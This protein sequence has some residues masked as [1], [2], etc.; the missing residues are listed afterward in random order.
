M[1]KWNK[2]IVSGSNAHLSSVTSSLGAQ[3]TGSVLVSSSFTLNSTVVGS[4]LTGSFS[5]SFS[6]SFEGTASHA[7]DLQR[8]NNV[9]DNNVN[10]YVVTATGGEHIQGEQY[11]QFDSGFTRNKLTIIGGYIDITDEEQSNLAIGKDTLMSNTSGMWN[12]AIG[13]AS[14]NDNQDGNRNISIGHDSLNA[15]LTG[16]DNIAIGKSSL[17]L[18]EGSSNLA[19]GTD[20]L[21]SNTSGQ[22]NIGI[23]KSSLQANTSGTDNIG[24][25]VGTL[26]SN[27]S[28]FSNISIGTN[29][30]AGNISGQYNIGIGEL[31]LNTNASG[32]N[33]ISLGY[34]SGMRITGNNNISVGSASLYHTSN[35]DSNIGIGIQSLYFNSASSNLAIG[36]NSSYLNRTGSRN[37]SIGNFSLYRNE[38][39]DN[40]SIGVSSSF[41]NFTGSRNLSIGNY[42]LRDLLNGI[43]NIS[44][45]FSSSLNLV[46]ASFNTSVGVGVFGSKRTGSF[47]T[48]I[49]YNAMS[50]IDGGSLDS[51]YNIAIGVESLHSSLPGGHNIGIG[52]HT[53]RNLYVGDLRNAGFN[54]IA[55]GNSAGWAV[56]TGGHVFIGA[57]A[58]SGS[59]VSSVRN[60][61][62]TAGSIIAIGSGSLKE[63]YG[64]LSGTITI[65]FDSGKNLKDS[66]NNIVIGHESLSLTSTTNVDH[67]I[68]IGNS[69][70]QYNS[71]NENVIIGNLSAIASGFAGASNVII[72]NKSG[73]SMTNSDYNVLIGY[74]VASRL[75]TGDFNVVMGGGSAGVSLTTGNYNLILGYQAA[76]LTVNLTGESNIVLGYAAG[77]DLTS[78][79]DNILIGKTAGGNLSTATGSIMIGRE[80]GG[81]T[82]GSA[83]TG[84][85]NI[86]LGEQS[87]FSLTSGI[88]NILIGHESGRSMTT[89]TGSV[90]L[91]DRAGKN[92]TGG[93]NV[94]IGEL[95]GDAASSTSGSILIGSDA[96]GGNLTGNGNVF[97]GLQSGLVASSATKNVFIGNK[98]GDAADTTTGSVVI[99]DNAGDALTSGNGNVFIG[100][101]AGGTITTGRNNIHIGSRAGNRTN[102]PG[103]NVPAGTINSIIIG[104]NVG[105]GA[106]ADNSVVLGGQGTATYYSTIATPQWTATSDENDKTDIANIGLGLDLIRQVQPKKYRW[107]NRGRYDNPGSRD[108][109]L[110]NPYDSWGIIAQDL[111][112]LTSSFAS[113][114]Y[115]IEEISGSYLD[116]TGFI[117]YG[118]KEGSLMWTTLQAV[119]DLDSIVATTGSNSFTGSQFITG[120]LVLTRTSTPTGV[121][122]DLYGSRTKGGNQYFDF[123]RITNTT[124]SAKTP[125]KT[126]RLDISGSIEIINDA[127]TSTIFSLNDSGS[128]A[129][130]A[131]NAVSLDGLKN[132]GGGVSINNGNTVIFDDGNTHIHSAGANQNIWINASGSGNLVVNGQTGASGGLLVGTSTA[133]GLVTISGSRN[134]NLGVTYGYLNSSGAT[135]T[136]SG[137]SRYSIV[138]TDRI[139]G[140]EFNAYSDIRIK[141]ITGKIS[142]D[143]AKKFI[144]NTNPIKFTWK[145]SVD[146]GIKNGYSAQEVL[147]AGFDNLVGAIPNESIEELIDADGFVS[148][149]GSQLTV[150][151]EQI[152]P[153]HSV[154]IKHLLDK[155]EDLEKQ[156]QELRGK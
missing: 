117:G 30:I 102:G 108:G 72:G 35:Y 21:K 148:P 7:K 61:S 110:K 11:L 42:S 65:G 68:V 26:F 144:I 3:F 135:G 111:V 71:G 154:V 143:E 69:T 17:K 124:G 1:A 53:L 79:R 29:A 85:G 83:I 81:D 40:L 36:E 12:I 116:G 13:S 64:T 19:I 128:L 18:N 34:M 131:T 136:F 96:G 107:D 31:S 46:S 80:S 127:Y 84:H 86:A 105:V 106:N 20:S 54:S 39:F 82:A 92:L 10:N 142:L 141:D 98:A 9:L 24:I 94:F 99:G 133:Q 43:G 78:G 140:S 121:G 16:D 114:S 145:N 58:A 125:S 75:T 150:N 156:V 101:L 147:K 134:Y 100:E 59:T 87:A 138:T 103:G 25:G 52:Y 93:K 95:A 113:M 23:G 32:D 91:G 44:V 4:R 112:A 22:E 28:G 104:N 70:A 56:G 155:I 97:I 132:T 63:G 146:D 45:G 57:G 48:A 62:A 88:K 89:G 33:N 76:G 2:I 139:A 90:L 151:Y 6:G 15:N 8:I 152:I 55:I 109:S 126:L 123:L 149:S 120:S 51:Q 115:L 119:K 27:Q 67:N 73:E 41:N 130:P 66:S 47:D 14:L 60:I 153:Y 77:F 118:V 122:L 38:D 50:R 5:G 74:D 129:L 37:I 49:G 137:I